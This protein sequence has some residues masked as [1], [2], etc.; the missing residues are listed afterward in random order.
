MVLD[1]ETTGLNTATDMITEI[2]AVRIEHGEEVAE[3]SELVNPGRMIPEKVVEL[4]GIT[5]AMVRDC[6]TIEQLA[7]RFMEFCRGAVLVAHNAAFDSAFIKR[8]FAPLGGL[9]G[10]PVLDTLALARNQYAGQMKNFKLGTIC[11][12]LGISLKNAH[13]AVHDARA[14]SKVLLRAL[15]SL[16]AQQPTVRQLD[17]LN[18]V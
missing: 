18:R 5:D 3:F 12:F 9:H 15:D 6:P 7:P 11:K 2:G 10:A 14:T 13:R 16:R 17:D 4:T 1:V 8:A